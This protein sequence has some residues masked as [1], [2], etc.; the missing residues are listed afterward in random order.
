MSED[1]KIFISELNDDTKVTV[2]E[3]LTVTELIKIGI[4]PKDNL[5]PL[6]AP[7]INENG[8]IK[9]LITD[10]V[11]SVTIITSKKGSVRSNHY[12]VANSHYLFLISGSVSYHERDIDGN[13]VKENIYK[14]GQMF[15][16]PPQR[17]HKVV[18]LEDTVMISMAHGCN[19]HD[20]HE[21]DLVRMEF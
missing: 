14:A 16:T 19:K 5:I 20:S 17:V 7:F 1:T 18:A 10:G 2:T 8:I 4:Y 3:L 21:E 9:N 13:N 12:H 11:D 6:D 15:F